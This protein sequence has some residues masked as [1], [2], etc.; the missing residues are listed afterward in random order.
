MNI[1]FYSYSIN[2]N[3][4]INDHEMKRLDHS[5]HSLREFNDEIPVYLFCDDPSFIPPHF[6]SEYGV[7]VL[8][9]EDQVNHGMLVMSYCSAGNTHQPPDVSM[10]ILL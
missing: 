5:I 6:T 1:V 10:Y 2:K 4:H 8:P 9:F 7:K 3:D